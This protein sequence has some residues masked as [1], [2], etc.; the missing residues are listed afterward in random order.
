VNHRIISHED[1]SI[2][3]A[4]EFES[5]SPFGDNTME[6][7]AVISGDEVIYSRVVIDGILQD[8]VEGHRAD[9]LMFVAGGPLR[10]FADFKEE[11]V[12]RAT[13]ENNGDIRVINLAF[14]AEMIAETIFGGM[15]EGAERA[16]LTLKLGENDQPLSL[17]LEINF[18]DDNRLYEDISPRSMELSVVF[19]AFGDDVVI[20]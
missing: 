20:N 6:V 18:S 7:Y 11:W 4:A 14:D 8:D 19:N 12:I 1:G 10:Q 9:D 15:N 2:R 13:L 17:S 5:Y 3:L 16:Y